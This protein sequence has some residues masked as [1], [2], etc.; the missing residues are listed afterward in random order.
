MM[1]TILEQKPD[2]VVDNLEDMSAIFKTSRMRTKLNFK[3]ISDCGRNAEQAR[4][5]W[6]LFKVNTSQCHVIL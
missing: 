1:T 5:E 4:A 3:E 6:N 2:N